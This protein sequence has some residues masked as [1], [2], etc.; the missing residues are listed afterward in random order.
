MSVVVVVVVVEIGVGVG[1]GGGLY[2]LTSLSHR[3]STSPWPA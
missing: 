1:R 2:V 3:Q